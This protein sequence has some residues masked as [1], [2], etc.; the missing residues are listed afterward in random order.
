VLYAR[1]KKPGQKMPRYTFR[2]R[3]DDTG[4]EDDTG[5]SLPDDDVAYRYA[6]DVVH[7]LMQRREQHT[8]SWQ[9]QVYEAEERKVFE[10]P[11]AR[12]DPTLDHLSAPLRDLV[13]LNAQRVRSLKDTLC[14]T[15]LTV[16]EA[17]SLVARSRGKP[18]LAVVRGRKII[19]DDP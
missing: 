13:E 1:W 14:A 8:R 12:L 15:R 2:L 4:V 11:F 7:E 9:L 19:R 18:Y 6:C 3:D 16:Q 10:I 5:V 17:T